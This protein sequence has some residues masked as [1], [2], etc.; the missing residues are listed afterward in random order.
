MSRMIM[1]LE[2]VVKR[3]TKENEELK[4]ENEQLHKALKAW[5]NRKCVCPKDM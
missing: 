1:T 4:K 5:T 3:L 2:K